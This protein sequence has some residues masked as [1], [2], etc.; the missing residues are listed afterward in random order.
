MLQIGLKMSVKSETWLGE[1]LFNARS[2]Q[3]S[4]M[5]SET[6]AAFPTVPL[7]HEPC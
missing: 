3:T 7:S 6:L 4:A 2:D 1:C 5:T